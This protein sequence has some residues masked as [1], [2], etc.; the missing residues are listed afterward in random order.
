M[1]K[2]NKELFDEVF[3]DGSLSIKVKPRHPMCNPT[4][5]HID[6]KREEKKKKCRK[7]LDND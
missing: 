3:G 5:P 2:I 4:V 1:G 6:K 7:P